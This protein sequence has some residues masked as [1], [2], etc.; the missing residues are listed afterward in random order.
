MQDQTVRNKP[1]KHSS[2]IKPSLLRESQSHIE[3]RAAEQDELFEQ[4]FQHHRANRFESSQPQFKYEASPQLN[5]P[6]KSLSA[7]NVLYI[8]I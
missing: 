6:G 8:C 7:G 2:K 5:Y 3:F 4:M 1:T